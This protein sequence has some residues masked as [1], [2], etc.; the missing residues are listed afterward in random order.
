M[1]RRCHLC[2]RGSGAG[3][4][5]SSLPT[6]RAR[7][8]GYL[9]QVPRQ[10]TATAA[11]PAA[12]SVLLVTERTSSTVTLRWSAAPGPV[13]GYGIY[14]DGVFVLDVTS[15]SITLTGLQCGRTYTF[16]VDAHAQGSRSERI[17]VAGATSTCPSGGGG[18][19]GGG[20]GG[21]RGGSDPDL[22]PPMPPP[23]SPPGT[24]TQSTIGVTWTAAT[25]NVGVAGYGLY[26]NGILVGSS[27][28]PSFNFTGLSCGTSY[29]LA[30]DGPTPQATAPRARS[31][32]L[33]PSRLL[34]RHPAALGA[35]RDRSRPGDQTSIAVTWSAS[36]DNVAVKGYGVY[37]SNVSVGSTDAATR[38][39]TFSGLSCGTSY[40]L[41]VDATDAAGNRL[42]QDLADRGDEQL[43]LPLTL[44]RPRFP[45]AWR[46]TAPPR[47]RPR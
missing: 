43:R 13:S 22:L 19:G 38:S 26:R 12:P 14:T 40:A 24:A 2:R 3:F 33:D 16:S 18:G 34:A 8:G 11:T 37:R 4:G 42:A 9:A 20:S 1:A 45:R 29:T 32:A 27:L 28:V 17:S 41:A 39:F 7:L 30:V 25:D 46:T 35:W 5:V 31:P 15:V 36:T 21:G 10:R 23:R 6:A 47:P 44:S